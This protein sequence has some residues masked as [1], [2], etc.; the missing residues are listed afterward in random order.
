MC[1]SIDLAHFQRVGWVRIADAIPVELCDRLVAVLERELGVPV[2]DPRRWN[3]YGGVMRDL[4]PIW[5][6][7]AQW[8]IRQYPPLHRIWATLWGREAL[9]V[10]LDSCRF[11]PPWNA[12]YAE[13]YGLHW[14]HDP[15]D[16]ETR[17][18]Q[19]VLALTD[20]AADQGGFCC[21]PSL[22]HDGISWPKAPVVDLD[23]DQN[24]LAKTAGHDIAFIPAKAG[25]L[26]VWDWRLPHSNSKN[27]STRPRLTFYVAMYPNTNTALRDAAI[28]S[29]RS[30]HCV[31]WWR[32]RWG[33][34]RIEP[35]P[36]ARLSEL[37]RRLI[38]LDAW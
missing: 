38:G 15:W 33:Y 21:V 13:P 19:G 24:W 12:G 8:D 10:T 34:D 29:W 16:E 17:M 1:L 7:Q 3:E 32:N 11:S 27:L 26:I 14:D 30:G 6:H 28:E 31:P 23:G 18:L 25:D 2:R 20:T 35:W 37:G 5:G 4:L 36:P 22:L 9:W